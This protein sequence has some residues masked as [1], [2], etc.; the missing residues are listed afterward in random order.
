M[1][2]KESREEKL[3]RVTE[4]LGVALRRQ[5]A[6]SWKRV[7]T[8]ER[9]EERRHV[10]RFRPETDGAVRFLGV[11]HDAMAEGDNPVPSLLEH[12]EKGRWLDRLRNGP[13][14]ALM[15]GKG[16]RLSGR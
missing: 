16:G 9:A 15:L 12:L 14:T 2:S 10:W 6:G 1:G 3:S 11:T 13:E 5:A 7:R 8:A 4:Q